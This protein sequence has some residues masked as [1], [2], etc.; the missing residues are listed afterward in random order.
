MA[1]NTQPWLPERLLRSGDYAGL[2]RTLRNDPIHPGAF[3]EADIAHYKQAIAQPG[4]LTAT[5]N[6]YRALFRINPLVYK[7]AIPRIDIPTL[8]IW[9]EQDRYLG[10]RLTEGLEPWVPK[11]QLERIPDAS[12]WVQAEV[13]ERVNAL[14]LDFLRTHG[15]IPPVI[16]SACQ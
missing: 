10:I 12:H 5:I 4:A 15:G 1:W 16:S 8:L 2:E 14:M 3:S 7:Q 13:P 6:Y 11:L 9:G